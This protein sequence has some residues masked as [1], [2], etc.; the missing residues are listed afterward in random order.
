[1]K[2]ID[3]KIDEI[4]TKPITK[5]CDWQTLYTHPKLMQSYYWKDRGIHNTKQR[6]QDL[7]SA[8]FIRKKLSVPK[9]EVTIKSS[10]PLPKD[11]SF[12]QADTLVNADGERP[13]TQPGGSR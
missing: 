10:S 12:R 2:E 8:L 1:M 6:V 4:L 3:K 9:P 11:A 5:D 13:S 7:E